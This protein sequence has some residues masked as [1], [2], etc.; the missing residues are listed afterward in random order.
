VRQVLRS[1][2]IEVRCRGRTCPF[3]KR[4]RDVGARHSVVTLTRW[5][6]GF[7]LTK[8]SRLEVRVVAPE[9]LGKVRRERLRGGRIKH[10]VLCLDPRRVDQPVGI[11]NLK[12]KPRRPRR[13]GECG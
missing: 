11:L 10:A 7:R 1:T 6:R 5:L 3:K 9:R 13:I 8:R 4:T 12:L 2:W